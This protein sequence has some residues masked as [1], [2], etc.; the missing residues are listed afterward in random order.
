M[1][2]GDVSGVAEEDIAVHALLLSKNCCSTWIILVYQP[3]YHNITF[4]EEKKIQFSYYIWGG[5]EIKTYIAIAIVTVRPH[6]VLGSLLK[7]SAP[8]TTF[9]SLTL[10]WHGG[11]KPDIYF[12][13]TADTITLWLSQAFC[14]KCTH[15][16]LDDEGYFLRPD[17]SRVTKGRYTMFQVE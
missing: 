10:Y 9:H 4:S 1:T 12:R 15:P 7:L 16:S 6:T 2:Q 17:S 13:T 3:Y 8:Q 5:I 11:M 14:Y